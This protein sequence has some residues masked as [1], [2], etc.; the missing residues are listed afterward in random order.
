MRMEVYNNILCIS[1][2]ELIRDERNPEGMMSKAVLDALVRRSQLIR[3]RRACRGVESLFDY[4]SLP[5]KYRR[6]WEDKHG[7]PTRQPTRARLIDFIHYDDEAREFYSNLV[8]PS[9]ELL[10]SADPSAAAKYTTN[11]SVLNGIGEY[12][13]KKTAARRLGGVKTTKKMLWEAISAG[14]DDAQFRKEWPHS[15]PIYPA[16]LRAKY[17]KYVAEGYTTLVHSGFGNDNSV[18]VNDKIKKI[19]HAI[20]AMPNRPFEVETAELYR[21][22]VAG[23]IKLVDKETGELFDRTSCQDAAGNVVELS[24]ATIRN[25]VNQPRTKAALAKRRTDAMYYSDRYMPHVR[26]NRSIMSLSRLTA[27]DRDLPRRDKSGNRP[28][29]YYIY[30]IGSTAVIGMAY[31]RKKDNDLFIE[32]LRDMFRNIYRNR[33]PMPAEIEVETHIVR[34]FYEEMTRLF[35][36]VHWCRPGNSQEKYAEKLNY[37]KKYEVEHR[38][39]PNVGRW[40]ARSE[41][42]KSK[43]APKLDDRYVERLWDFDQLVEEDRRDCN[44]YNNGLHPNQKKYPG[45]TRLQVLVEN[46]NPN[47]RQPNMAEIAY[48]IGDRVRTSIRRNEYFVAN[49]QEFRLPSPAVLSKLAAGNGQITACVLPDEDGTAKEAYVYQNGRY[50]CT[51]PLLGRYNSATIERT[52]EDNRIFAEQMSYVS[53]F[54]AQVRSD[55][56]EVPRVAVLKREEYDRIEEVEDAEEFVVPAEQPAAL[57]AGTDDDL[58]AAK[59]LAEINMRKIHHYGNNV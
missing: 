41:A 44:E 26:M 32:C 21:M 58:A 18:K 6:L 38:N 53:L 45:K 7:D 24:D 55:L 59:N 2:A 4:S 11:A 14:I 46:V 22:F 48:C 33:L 51:C 5:L 36:F 27:D 3:I 12:I 17:E 35:P 42:Y 29:A 28:K 43:R 57:L 31:S 16:K 13:R 8:L 19:V 20:H 15:L 25:I 56:D 1:G 47:L 30:D 37:V 34:N 23:K 49:R 39:H 40:W 52:E 54:K 9:G 10:I 50:V